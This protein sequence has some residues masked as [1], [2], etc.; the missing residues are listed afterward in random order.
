ML[1]AL[2]VVLVV[3][4]VP[5][6]LLW[7][8]QRRL[9]Y[10]PSAQAPA[11]AAGV[12]EVVLDTSDG[13]RLGAWLV[14]G[15]SDTAVLVTHGNAGDRG[16]R[17][18]LGRALAAAGHTVLLVDYRGYGG[19]PGSPSEEGL[20]RDAVAAWEYLTGPGGFAPERIVLFG[21]S[22]GAAV[23]TRLAADRAAAPPR[24]LVLRSPFRSLA[25]VGRVHHPYLPVGALLRDRFPVVELIGRVRVPTVVVYGTADTVVPPAQSRAVAGAAPH[26]LDAV[27]VE[28]ADHNDA[29]LGAGPAVVDAVLRVA[30]GAEGR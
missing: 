25:A 21:E 29:V 27:A 16:D 19:N 5:V 26:L 8:F 22:L 18:P 17:L 14:P 7:S 13:L 11:V 23:A 10:F 24:G 30:G 4:V 12:R 20:T 3:L 15:T 28:G 1:R 2:V 6:A 9:V